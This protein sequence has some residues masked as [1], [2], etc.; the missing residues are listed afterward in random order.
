M[1]DETTPT[2]KLTVADVDK[3]AQVYEDAI[4]AIVLAP[5][6]ATAGQLRDL[7]DALDALDSIR[8]HLSGDDSEDD[9]YA[10]NK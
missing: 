6:A 8:A 10:G 2:T 1:A 7:M 3:A 9:E 4:D 5:S